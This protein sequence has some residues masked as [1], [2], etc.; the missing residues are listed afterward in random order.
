MG[1]FMPPIDSAPFSSLEIGIGS[2]V[3]VLHFF[4]VHALRQDVDQCA[5][6]LGKVD[7]SELTVVESGSAF[8]FRPLVAFMQPF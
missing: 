6:S 3:K 1:D 7:L 2:S 5:M 4:V 8:A